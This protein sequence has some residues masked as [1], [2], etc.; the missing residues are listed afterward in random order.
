MIYGLIIAAGKQSRFN[1]F[2]IN[3]GVKAIEALKMVKGYM[4]DK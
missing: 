3:P 1:L 4:Y 2:T